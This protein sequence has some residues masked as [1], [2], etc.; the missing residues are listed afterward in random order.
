[1]D[2]DS[3]TRGSCLNGCIR[4]DTLSVEFGFLK[5]NVGVKNVSHHNRELDINLFHNVQHT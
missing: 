3:K 4:M 2:I 5:L 1:V